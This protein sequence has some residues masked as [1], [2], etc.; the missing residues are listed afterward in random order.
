MFWGKIIKLKMQKTKFKEKIKN[1]KN[2]ASFLFEAATLKRLKRTGWQ[3]LG[4]N[5]ES[6]AEHSFMVCVVSFVLG[7]KLKADLEKVLILAL[8][9]DFSET[10][11]GDVYKLADRYVEV[12]EKKAILD[13]FAGLPEKRQIGKILEDYQKSNNLE[14]KIVHDADT[15]ALCLELKLMMEKGDKHAKEWLE[16]NINRLRLKESKR[17]LQEILITDSQDWWKK[18]REELHRSFGGK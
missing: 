15:L 7:K 11:T 10:R 4:G 3:I 18:E 6:V 13:S 8:F 17:L 14:V 12:K 5:N 1:D 16:A 9:H 2:T